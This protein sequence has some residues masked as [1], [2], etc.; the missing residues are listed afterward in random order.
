MKQG[1]VLKDKLK[2]I[3][4]KKCSLVFIFLVSLLVITYKMYLSFN[5][6]VT[7]DSSKYHYYTELL[8]GNEPM[9]K[10]D[11]ERGFS[12]PLI[13]YLSRILFGDSS[14]AFVLMFFIFYFVMLLFV[15][16]FIKDIINYNE[17]KNKKIMYYLLFLVLFP[18]NPL[19]VG[20]G[21]YM[22]TEAV[23][24]TIYFINLYLCYKWWRLKFEKGQRIRY[25]LIVLLFSLISVFVWFLK[26]PYAP[27]VWMMIFLAAVL[28]SV[29]SRSWRVLKEKGLSVLIV[30]VVT[31]L[32]I[33]GWGIILNHY[34]VNAS[35]GRNSTFYLQNN[36]LEGISYHIK[37]IDPNIA[38]KKE[39][40]D[41]MIMK[42]KKKNYLYS[43]MGQLD[44]WCN[45]I[46]IFELTDNDGRVFKHEYF[47][48]HGEQIELS[49]VLPFVIKMY[50]KYPFTQLD[51]LLAGYL[52]ITDFYLTTNDYK[53]TNIYYGLASK[54]IETSYMSF[55]KGLPNT[56]WK[57]N[58]ENPEYKAYFNE[59]TLPWINSLK[60]IEG[61]TT[62]SDFW[63][64]TMLLLEG[65]ATFLFKILLLLCLPIGIYSFIMF[66]KY[67][68]SKSY[69]L[70][71]ITSV[72][73]F[74]HIMFHVFMGA[75]IDRYVYPIYPLMLFCLILL[76]MQNNNLSKF[77]IQKS[78]N[79]EERSGGCIMS[80]KKSDKVLFVIP[81]YNEAT[82]IE[83]VLKEI[84]KDVKYADILIIND[85]SKDNTRQIVLRNN[86][87]CIDNIFNMR[88]A[89]AVQTGIKY[90][91]KNE[92]DYVIQMDA[93]GQ[94]IAKEA[95]K[96]YKAMLSSNNDIIIGSRYLEDLGYK[97]PFFRRIGT[98]I[99]ELLVRL[100]CKKRIT[101]PMSGFQCLNRRIIEE[102]ATMGRYPEYPDANLLIE[103]IRLGYNVDEIPVKMRNR[104]SG[105]SMHSGIMKPIKY[106]INIFYTIFFI[107][108]CTPKKRKV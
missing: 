62:N 10:W 33:K 72:S 70:M 48:Y 97:C 64:N 8:F 23:I 74:A 47:I 90:A 84:Q 102:Y 45:K 31:L 66:I 46:V 94:H 3:N 26:Q 92:Y 24:P 37:A 87:K 89:M 50:I 49:D 65:A 85:C 35:E 6:I 96:L 107:V 22:L 27:A 52:S 56:W 19:I 20:W 71:V 38:C 25:T 7:I 15:L 11:V 101:D 2:K 95:E 1:D 93:D 29:S 53:A 80:N 78:K 76:F 16:K 51:T 99:F 82:N 30:L 14:R 63:G 39:Y 57:F 13:L 106:M 98:K 108:I 40:V 103:M 91:Y 5:V 32:S 105:V 55:T 79:V 54:E 88:Y 58:E 18:F 104:T 86:V 41:N 28:D 42:D 9:S 69:Y 36:L 77:K 12:L 61:T 67:P 75:I 73:S 4:W 59:Q 100:F 68:K 60:Y 44:N 43:F 17:I 83:K 34:G 81:A 21:H